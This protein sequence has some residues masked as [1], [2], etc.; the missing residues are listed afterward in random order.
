MKSK[1]DDMLV[2][3]KMGHVDPAELDLLRAIPGVTVIRYRE[4]CPVVVQ[5]NSFTTCLQ[6]E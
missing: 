4:E 6:D 2:F 3:V 5:R 1:N